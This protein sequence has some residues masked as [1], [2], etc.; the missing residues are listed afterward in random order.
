MRAWLP[1]RLSTNSTASA[2]AIAL[3]ADD[4]DYEPTTPTFSGWPSAI[5]PFA[6]S[7]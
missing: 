6:L 2:S 5:W 3:F 4:R 1:V 7:A